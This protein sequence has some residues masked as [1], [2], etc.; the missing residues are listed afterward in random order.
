MFLNIVHI[1]ESNIITANIGKDKMQTNYTVGF[2][3]LKF[4]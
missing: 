3:L 4:L 2:I 1:T